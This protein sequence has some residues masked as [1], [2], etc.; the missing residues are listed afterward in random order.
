MIQKNTITILSLLV[1]V[2][3]ACTNLSQTANPEQE[4]MTTTTTKKH[5]FDRNMYPTVKDYLVVYNYREGLRSDNEGLVEST[6]FN[7]LALR[8]ANPALNIDVL[9]QELGN[10]QRNANSESIRYKSMLALY[11]LENESL[12]QDVNP[13]DYNSPNAYFSVLANT[14]NTKFLGTIA[15]SK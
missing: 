8:L 9:H 1:L 15:Q 11:A 14:M 12:L 13:G 10:L 4:N 5:R 3:A 6:I 2:S 7:A